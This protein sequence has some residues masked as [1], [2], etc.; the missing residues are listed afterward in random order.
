MT[1]LPLNV[2]FTEKVVVVTGA[3]GV[4][5]EKLPGGVSFLCDDKAAFAITGVVLPADA[6]F[7]AYSGV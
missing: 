2:D 3:D 5:S 7:A 4:E 6:E 1:D